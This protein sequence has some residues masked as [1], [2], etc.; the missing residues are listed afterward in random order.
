MFLNNYHYFENKETRILVF[1]IL[2]SAIVR[3]PVIFLFG[4]IALENEWKII[5]NNLIEHRKFSFR[6]FDEF[7]LPNLY[8]PPLYA[9]YLYFFSFFK[10]NY[11]NY[12]LLILFSQVLLSSISVAVFYKINKNFFSKKISLF[13]SML[14]SLFPIYVYSCSQ[15][16]SISLQTFL[17]IFFLYFFL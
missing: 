8:M 14:L 4:D 13:G 7:Y 12:I 2:F 6:N 17:L 16:S 10:L 11:P 15:I 9:F 1:L 5:V 3:I